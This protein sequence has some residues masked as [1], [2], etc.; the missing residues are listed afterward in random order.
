MVIWNEKN[1]KR[2][3]EEIEMKLDKKQ[4]V[5][6][7]IMVLLIISMY[8]MFRLGY[9]EGLTNG[10]TQ[11]VNTVGNFLCLYNRTFS[12]DSNRVCGC[13]SVSNLATNSSGG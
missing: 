5:L 4:A 12:C 9:Q 8:S 13:F 6:I 10:R 1:T 3:K 11:G 7:A 2:T